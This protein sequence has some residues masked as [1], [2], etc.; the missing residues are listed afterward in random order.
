M[1]GAVP[2]LDGGADDRGHQDEQCGGDDRD[3][4]VRQNTVH[5]V[6]AVS[7]RAGAGPCGRARLSPVMVCASCPSARRRRGCVLP[8]VGG[9]LFAPACDVPGVRLR[10][11]L[12]VLRASGLSPDGR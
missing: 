6:G 2:V 9:V 8:P 3:Q 11:V 10:H 7:H 1:Q 4:V 5:R 12:S